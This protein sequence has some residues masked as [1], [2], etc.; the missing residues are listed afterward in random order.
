MSGQLS[1]FVGRERELAELDLGLGEAAAGRG[2]V[3]LVVGEPGIGK[4]R[5][6]D[7]VAVKATQR[8]FGVCWGR[9]WEVG[10]AP[11]YWPWI[12]VLRALTRGVARS[13]TSVA[14]ALTRLMPDA[15]PLSSSSDMTHE[16]FRLFD[17]VTRVI[18]GTADRQPL[19]LILDDLHAA[20][21]SSLAL[22]EFLARDVKSSH[23]YLLGTYRDQEARRSSDRG[24]ALGRIAREAT[25]L[26]LARF[27]AAEVKTL[28]ERHGIDSDPETIGRVA[29]IT[30]GH[31][32]FVEEICRVMRSRGKATGVVVPVTVRDAIRDRLSGMSKETRTALEAAAVL[33]RDLDARTLANVLERDPLA[34]GPILDEAEQ[35]GVLVPLEEGAW[36]FSHA[37][38][39]DAL[40][41]EIPAPERSRLHARAA[42]VLESDAAPESAFGEVASHL[43]SAA[44]VVG[45]SRALQGAVRAAERAMQRYAFEDAVAILER[46]VGEL[47]PELRDPRALG[48]A[49]VLVGE[50]RVRA[51]MDGQ[52]AC[53]RAADLARELS[54]PELL[55]RAGLALGAEI[56]PALSNR[57]MIGILEEALEKLPKPPSALRARTLAR[58]AGALQPA[59]DPQ[60]PIAIAREAIAMARSLDD[61]ATLAGVLL[62]AGSALVDYAHPAERLEIDRET[63][64][65]AAR[66]ADVPLS[67]RA[68][69]RLFFDHAEVGDRDA[70]LTCLR[71]CERISEDLGRP[72]YRF[73]VTLLR[74]VLAITEAD[75]AT[76]DALE[77]PAREL[78]GRVD[79]LSLL[80][81][82][83]QHRLCKAIVR[84]DDAALEAALP[85]MVSALAS[86]P[87]KEWGD[88]LHGFLYARKGR[89]D[90][91]LACRQR[92]PEQFVRS[93]APALHL[94]SE[95][96]FLANDRDAAEA[97][98][99][100]LQKREGTFLIWGIS[101]MG[102]FGPYTWLLA[103]MEAV[104][105]DWAAAEAHFQTAI[106]ACER[107]GMRAALGQVLFDY[108]LALSRRGDARLGSILDRTRTL[109][110]ERNMPGLLARAD[111][112]SPTPAPPNREALPA[113]LQFRFTRE[114]D[115]WRVEHGERAFRLKD[116]RGLCMLARLIAEP[117]REH[118]VLTLGREGDPGDLGD[119]GDVLDSEAIRQYR[120]RLEALRDRESDAVEQGD[121]ARADAARREI[122]AIARE[123]AGGVGLGGRRRK[124]NAA[125]ERARTNVQRRIK[126]AIR[127]IEAE[128]PELGRYLG[129]TVKTGSFCVFSSNKSK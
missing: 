6:A 124:A 46:A 40:Y 98:V 15:A 83:V 81:S 50:A 125:A 114:G 78:A 105:D 126:D 35:H 107:V 37:L 71:E 24:E 5:V 4:T 49:L 120:E 47:E 92:I 48:E 93:E 10:G 36:A 33:G 99:P 64:R 72:Q 121:L 106:V 123:L 112:I 102:V 57:V 38:V 42:D 86:L 9:C 85:E 54:D 13:D 87:Q 18:T 74:A 30:E 23:L 88:A 25:Y 77:G 101:G 79:D 122:D 73:Y 94:V 118:H 63:L 129:W 82:L 80:V 69:L 41:R 19:M 28:L 104:L 3:Y 53:T 110:S 100:P 109:A 84:Q 115:V 56:V 127:R 45:P 97:L 51:R 61:P 26:P 67:F 128:D 52:S 117:G 2:G 90:L 62:G 96:I 27:D 12:Q 76:A 21:P 89:H 32:L 16:R 66:V 68:N 8:G 29:S 60:G 91:A 22:L 113:A 70:Q 14:E 75:F 43:L 34:L 55:A 58:L 59:I 20:D 95:Q 39:R 111:S 44:S 1:T 108:A 31:P 119:A 65:I 11:A 116:S 7:G 103:R 17:S